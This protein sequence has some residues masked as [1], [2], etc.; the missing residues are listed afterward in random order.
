MSAA[1]EE[2]RVFAEDQRRERQA[3]QHGKQRL[4]FPLLH[5]QAGEIAKRRFSQQQ[6]GQ[7]NAPAHI[8]PIAGRQE[9]RGAVFPRAQ[10]IQRRHRGQ[11]NEIGYGSKAHFSPP[12]SP[13][14][15]MESA[16]AI[17][18]VAAP[19]TVPKLRIHTAAPAQLNSTE[20]KGKAAPPF[21]SA[22][23]TG[24]ISAAR[25]NRTQANVTAS[26]PFGGSAK[27]RRRETGGSYSECAM[28]RRRPAFVR[29]HDSPP[30]SRLLSDYSVSLPL[31]ERRALNSF[32]VAAS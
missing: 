13:D 19:V 24:P 28:R 29:S 3:Q 7:R 25:A 27:D 16:A 1:E 4:A 31:A 15:S 6:Q 8:K 23:L 2:A 14:S 22:R 32:S 12:P 21:P 10:P 17:T 11:K 18:P 26:A 5:D 20:K 30:A 9:Q